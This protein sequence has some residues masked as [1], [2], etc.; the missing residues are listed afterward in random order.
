MDQASNTSPLNESYKM[1]GVHINPVLDFREHLTH[2]TKDV[3]KVAKA[4]AKRK[5]SSSFKTL[6][7]EQLLKSKYHATHLGVLNDYQ[8]TETDGVLNTAL[9]QATCFVP[10]FPTERV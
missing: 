4:L 1:L 7:I 6:L 8:L 9:N 2:I 5:L 3:R 10:N